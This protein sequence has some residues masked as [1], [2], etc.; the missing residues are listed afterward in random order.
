[1]SVSPPSL[2][3][4]T[5]HNP[6]TLTTSLILLLSLFTEPL[7]ASMTSGVNVGVRVPSSTKCHCVSQV[8]EIRVAPG[9]TRDMDHGLLFSTLGATTDGA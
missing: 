9:S 1:M 5:E 7:S 2:H 8:L 6:A 4:C 3:L